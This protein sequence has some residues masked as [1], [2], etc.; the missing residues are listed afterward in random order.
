M[1][2]LNLEGLHLSEFGGGELDEELHGALL[3]I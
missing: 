3:S 1:I 2:N